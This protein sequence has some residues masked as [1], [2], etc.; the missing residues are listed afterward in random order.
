LLYNPKQKPGITTFGIAF[1]PSNLS[2]LCPLSR[3]LSDSL[4]HL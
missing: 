3:T 1:Y 4:D 2:T